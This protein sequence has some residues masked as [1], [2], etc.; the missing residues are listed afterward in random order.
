MQEFCNRYADSFHRWWED[1]DEVRIDDSL[2][3]SLA[4]GVAAEGSG[5]PVAELAAERDALIT[6]MLEA[7]RKLRN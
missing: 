4:Q 6:A 3:E 1:L 5:K 2:A 7:T